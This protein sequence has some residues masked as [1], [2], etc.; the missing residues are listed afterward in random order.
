MI[1]KV[2]IVGVVWVI[3]KIN[4]ALKE[5]VANPAKN[6]WAIRKAA[7][8]AILLAILVKSKIAKVAHSKRAAV[9]AANAAKAHWVTNKVASAQWVINKRVIYLAKAMI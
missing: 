7:N 6:Q 3:I 9:K 1:Y 5:T 4:S 8:A 2:E